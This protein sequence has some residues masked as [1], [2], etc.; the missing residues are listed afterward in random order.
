MSYMLEKCFLEY[1]S[2]T[3]QLSG[4]GEKHS[5]G[6]GWLGVHVRHAILAPAAKKES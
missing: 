6:A 1:K 2:G 4:T 3:R 5:H